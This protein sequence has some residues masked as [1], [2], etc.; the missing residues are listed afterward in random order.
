[1]FSLLIL[2][3]DELR[4]LILRRYPGGM[5]VHVTKAFLYVHVTKVFLYVH[6]TKAF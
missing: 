3:Y 4:K 1:M 5:Y 2:V 6:V